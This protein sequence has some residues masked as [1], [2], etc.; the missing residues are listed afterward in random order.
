MDSRGLLRRG[1]DGMK[2]WDWGRIFEIVTIA[3]ILLMGAAL[4]TGAV[5][6]SGPSKLFFYNDMRT[7]SSSNNKVIMQRLDKDLYRVDYWWTTAQG[8]R[9]NHLMAFEQYVEP[10]IVEWLN[11]VYGNEEDRYYKVEWHNTDNVP[12]FVNRDG[13]R[14]LWLI[15]VIKVHEDGG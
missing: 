3:A 10:R 5:T 14:I 9:P 2:R 13:E 4:L 15:V 7:E 1:H 6:K 8:G 12:I 11:Y